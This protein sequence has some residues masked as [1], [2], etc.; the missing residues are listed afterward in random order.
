VHAEAPSGA[1]SD[2]IAAEARQAQRVR[3]DGGSDVGLAIS[4][5]AEGADTMVHVGIVTPEG[6]HTEKR[7]TFMRGNQGADRA[8]I[9]AASV[10]LTVL[11]GGATA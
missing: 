9:A 10:L 11:R 1:A 2:E 5:G 7:V 6:V 3:R 4:I 8:A